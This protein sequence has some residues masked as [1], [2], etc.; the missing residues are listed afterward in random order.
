MRLP[1]L[2][3]TTLAAALLPAAASAAAKPP[4]GISDQNVST[5]ASPLFA[6]LGMEHARYVTPY[7]AALKDDPTL[8][9]WIAAARAAGVEPLISFEKSHGQMCPD[10][11]CALPRVRRFERAF[12]A[13]R[14]K[15]PDIRTI[16]PWNEASHKTQ[17]TYG[18]PKRAAAYYHAVKRNCAGCTIV[19]ADLL[20]AGN[21]KSWVTRFARHA[22]D[23]RLWGLHNYGDANRFRTTGIDQLLGAV[24]GD[25]WL[26]ETGSIVAFTTSSGLVSFQKSERRAAK[27][28]RYLFDE[29][30]PHSRRI[31]RVYVY[32]WLSDPEN[33][34]D[35]G[36]VRDDGTPRRIYR[37]VKRYVGA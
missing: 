26:T 1:V 34:W 6:P 35:S 9:A 29:L 18:S 27:A 33:R 2:L 24:K 28:M 12:K 15:Y 32:N 30:V 19:A 22:P 5:F 13:F 17:P 37:I 11:P 36:L 25:V 14:A 21:M 10:D 20:D 31:K 16:S 8:D 4:V 7:D 23:A 3:L